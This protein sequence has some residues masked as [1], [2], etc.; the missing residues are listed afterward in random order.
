[1]SLDDW[2]EQ[3]PLCSG[4]TQFKTQGSKDFCTEHSRNRSYI[5]KP[6]FTR[7]NLFLRVS[8]NLELLNLTHEC[9]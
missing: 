3:I 7:V 1:M 6:L 2:K 4:E 5:L 9:G 8:K